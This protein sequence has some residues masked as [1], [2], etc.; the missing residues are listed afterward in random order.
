MALGTGAAYIYSLFITLFPTVL[1][2]KGLAPDVY[3][4]AA[5]VIIALL[6]LGRYLE[7][8]ARSQTSDAIRQ[9][10]D[11]QAN[12]ARIIRNGEEVEL[13][14]EDV[15]VGGDVVVVRPGEKIPVDGVVVAGISTVD[16]SM[17]TGEPMPVKKEQDETVIGSTIN[18]TGSFRFRASRVGSDTMLA[19]I[20]QLVQEAQGSKAPIQRVADQVTGWFVPVVI[21]IALLTFILWFTLMG[22]ITLALLTAVGVLI[23]ACPCALG[24]ATPTSIMVG[25]GKGAGKWHPH[26]ECRKS[27]ACS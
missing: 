5:V 9:L 23:I 17:V 27:R 4:E 10:M 18:K 22:N 2:S 8:R 21:A 25:T 12:T 7:N 15:I 6:L 16:E 3:Y 24:L 19:Q 11:L 26:Q 20:V 1:V 13:P 14:L